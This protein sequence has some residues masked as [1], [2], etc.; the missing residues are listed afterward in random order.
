MQVCNKIGY[1]ESRIILAQCAIY[2]TSS[3]KSNSAY[4]AIN[5][6]L[7]EIKMEK[8]LIYQNTLD[9]PTYWLSLSS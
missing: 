6:A 8:F 1:P 9:S 4:K 2:L 5:K 3:P 7:E